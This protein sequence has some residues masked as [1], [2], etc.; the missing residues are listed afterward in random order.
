MLR[1]RFISQHR[2]VLSLSYFV[3]S[4]FFCQPAAVFWV[5]NVVTSHYHT[6][7]HRNLW[8]LSC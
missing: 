6:I 3:L 1:S 7:Y 5:R 2:E 4:R 8:H